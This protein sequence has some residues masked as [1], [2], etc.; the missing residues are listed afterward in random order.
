MKKVLYKKN[1]QLISLELDV[2]F[3]LNNTN[4]SAHLKLEVVP[5]LASIQCENC[6]KSTRDILKSNG[7]EISTDDTSVDILG[8]IAEM[9]NTGRSITD[10]DYVFT[11]ILINLDESKA[12][13]V[14]DQTEIQS[15]KEVQ[16]IQTHLERKL[17]NVVVC[18]S[19][20][21]TTEHINNLLNK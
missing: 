9:E 3:S 15:R 14:D 19:C 16:E 12:I 4:Y 7:I 6:A 11:I 18:D 21:F 17:S 10:P 2:Q 8:I 5:V 13:N 1:Q 20:F